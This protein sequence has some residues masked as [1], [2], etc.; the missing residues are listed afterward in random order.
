MWV[1]AIIPVDSKD[2]IIYHNFEYQFWCITEVKV[3]NYLSSVSILLYM[4]VCL[5]V[6]F[7]EQYT[8]KRRKFQELSMYMKQNN[9]I[10]PFSDRKIYVY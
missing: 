5:S 8:G 6:I 2:M 4:S 7:W 3:I 1:G 9:F 10:N